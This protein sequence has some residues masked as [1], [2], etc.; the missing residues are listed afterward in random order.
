MSWQ[1]VLMANLLLFD[2][3]FGP[4]KDEFTDGVNSAKEPS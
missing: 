1:N 3:G 2:T 4:S